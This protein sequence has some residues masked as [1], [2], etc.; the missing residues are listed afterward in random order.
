MLAAGL[1]ASSTLV[2]SVMTAIRKP[3]T[4]K[5]VSATL[6][7]MYEG[8]FRHLPV[9]LP[10]GRPIGVLSSRDALGLKS[11]ASA[12]NSDQRAVLTARFL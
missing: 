4:R 5:T 7:L 2:G 12:R 10:D 1:E 9:V 6:H 11:C 3:F 8:G